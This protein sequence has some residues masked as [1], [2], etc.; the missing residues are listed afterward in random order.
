LCKASTASSHL[1]SSELCPVIFL[2]SVSVGN[3]I[4]VPMQHAVAPHAI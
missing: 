4:M 1:L 3:P 2:S